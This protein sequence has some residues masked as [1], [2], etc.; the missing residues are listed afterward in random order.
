MMKLFLWLYHH[1]FI[2]WTVIAL[3]LPLVWQV[4]YCDG[5]LAEPIFTGT[6]LN[7]PLFL[8]CSFLC[9]TV[10]PGNAPQA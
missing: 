9:W 4:S 7:I 3:F 6:Q 1:V 8:L 10:C 5:S 2:S